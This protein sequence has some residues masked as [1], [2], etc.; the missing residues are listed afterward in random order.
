MS[1]VKPSWNDGVNEW[2]GQL[3]ADSI[4]SSRVAHF[5]SHWV[6]DIEFESVIALWAASVFALKTTRS[7]LVV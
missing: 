5:A 2:L 7:Q 4:S 3:N 6:N 1:T